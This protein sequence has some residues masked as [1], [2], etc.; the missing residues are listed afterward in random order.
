MKMDKIT[1]YMM[2]LC[3]GIA[4]TIAGWMIMDS[5]EKIGFL[6]VAIGVG[7]FLD[8]LKSIAREEEKEL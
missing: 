3:L 8:S 6:L 7:L 2:A 4:L 1:M 5:G